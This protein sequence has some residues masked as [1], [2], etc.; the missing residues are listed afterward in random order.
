MSDTPGKQCIRPA[1]RTLTYVCVP[2]TVQR[3]E[4]TM[5]SC[6]ATLV[7]LVAVV[8]LGLGYLGFIPV[9]A[10]VFGSDKPRDLGVKA[11]AADLQSANGNTGVKLTEL[12]PSS[13]PQGSCLLY[14]S[15]AAD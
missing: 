12:P 13:S 10:G 4:R 2:A 9:V 6:L 7:V 3:E 11:T 1:R 14:T 5:R 8:V 15:D